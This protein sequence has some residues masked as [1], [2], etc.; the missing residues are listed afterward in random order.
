[1]KRRNFAKLFKGAKKRS[2]FLKIKGG[3]WRRKQEL[4]RVEEILSN[5]KARDQSNGFEAEK[6]WENRSFLS[7]E[8]QKIKTRT[9]WILEKLD[10]ESRKLHFDIGRDERFVDCIIQFTKQNLHHSQGF[11]IPENHFQESCE[12]CRKSKQRKTKTQKT[13]S[14]TSVELHNSWPWNCLYWWSRL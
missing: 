7:Q 13:Y 10:V 9:P 2:K 6:E 11:E 8:T 12:I 3:S 5:F 1:M 14:K 4:C